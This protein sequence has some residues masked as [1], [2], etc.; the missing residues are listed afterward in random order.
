MSFNNVE[1]KRI[2]PY[3]KLKSSTT[4]REIETH[5]RQGDVYLMDDHLENITAE[6]FMNGDAGI[7]AEY[8]DSELECAEA[9]A[10]DENLIESEHALSERFDD[11]LA[12]CC[13]NFDTD[14]ESAISEAFSNYKDSLE[15]DGELHRCQVNEYCYVGKH[16]N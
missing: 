5:L 7:Y 14:D 6:E 4:M 11:M 1:I 15:T 16:S 2:T 13:P 3:I 9:Y 8:Y 12:E 10:S